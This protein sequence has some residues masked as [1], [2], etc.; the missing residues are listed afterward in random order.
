MAQEK[1][2][3]EAEIVLRPWELGVAGVEEFWTGKFTEEALEV[4]TAAEG[5][6]AGVGGSH[7]W[8]A[9]AESLWTILMVSD[10][11][12]HRDVKLHRGERHY[13]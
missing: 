13:K 12:L 2:V 9:N 8:R 4:L 10:F 5:S 11:L 1:G 6:V 7:L 3:E